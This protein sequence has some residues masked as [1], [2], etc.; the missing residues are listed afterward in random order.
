MHA[1]AIGSVRR[2]GVVGRY[3]TPG[4]AKPLKRLAEFIA[5]RGLDVWMETETAALTRL[6]G[7]PTASVAEL[8]N[9]VD[10]V[11]VVG[12]DGTLLAVGRQLA[13]KRIPLI[14]INQGRLGFLTDIALADME[15][16]LADM[17]KGKLCV[18]ERM[19]LRARIVR[20]E[21]ELT[22]G[23]AFNDVVVNRGGFGGMIDLSVAIGD[24]Y[25]C[26]LRADG[27]I[28]ATPTGSTAYAMSANGPI[29]HP[30]VRAWSLVP[31]SPHALSNRPIVIGDGER[32]KITV[33]RAREA[34][35]HWDGQ[36]HH[37]LH[38]GDRIDIDAA[39]FGVR[40]LHPQGY[41]YYAMLRRKLHWSA[42]PLSEDRGSKSDDLGQ[43][44]EQERAPAEDSRQMAQMDG[45][46]SQAKERKGNA[47]TTKS[48]TT[49][50]RIG[51]GKAA[52]RKVN[53]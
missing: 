15:T 9:Q 46:V 53:R 35:M 37:T 14:G 44:M 33:T 1:F 21:V 3:N 51:G 40:L 41:D 17:F 12:G 11:I 8:G 27:V 31:I 45:A 19:L 49:L 26:D 23:L 20:D 25:V 36:S 24:S 32:V 16:V 18:E 50:R 4:I 48:A 30:S 6:P 39:P 47:A 52:A 38:E 13:E 42:S 10:L 34:A 2:V 28:V 29:V 5:A 7:Y 43:G 22:S